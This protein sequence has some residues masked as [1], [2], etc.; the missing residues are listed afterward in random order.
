[1]EQRAAERLDAWSR[2]ATPS[3]RASGVPAPHGDPHR[4]RV[5]NPWGHPGTETRRRW[6]CV[7]GALEARSRAEDGAEQLICSHK[8]VLTD[9]TGHDEQSCFV[10]WRPTC[11]RR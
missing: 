3:A 8:M 11:A 1:V 9:T 7:R 4:R 2:S 5:A 6:R 10:C